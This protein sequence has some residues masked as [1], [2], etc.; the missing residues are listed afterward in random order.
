VIVITYY[1]SIQN[2]SFSSQNGSISWNV[3]FNWDTERF[4]RD[5]SILVHQEVKVPKRLAAS[6]TD[7][8]VGKVNREVQVGRSFIV[9]PFS[10]Q[11]VFPIH[12]I[13]GNNDPVKMA[14]SSD[15]VKP[16]GDSDRQLMRFSFRGFKR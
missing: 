15:I 5:Q 4:K 16:M 1:D 11:D 9:D 14:N 2:F 13:I 6:L 8:F 7:I 3:P 10:S 12:Y